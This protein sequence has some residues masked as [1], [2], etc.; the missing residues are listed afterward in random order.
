M[1]AW[2]GQATFLSS[3]I[4]FTKKI[5]SIFKSHLER[6]R[7]SRLA[8]GSGQDSEDNDNYDESEEES[9]KF[10]VIEKK[11][12]PIYGEDGEI[13]DPE[14]EDARIYLEEVTR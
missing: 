6:G 3:Q 10:P 1:A 8:G 4:W 5:K 9:D 7:S 14:A 12:E 11:R 13:I 2:P